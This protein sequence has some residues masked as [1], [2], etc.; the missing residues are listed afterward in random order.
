MR[1]TELLIESIQRQCESQINSSGNGISVEE[2]LDHL[3]AA[4]FGLYSEIV[5]SVPDILLAD[6]YVDL[7]AGQ[8][9]YDLPS[10]LHLGSSIKSIW[11]K[12]GSG[13]ADYVKIPS[14]IEFHR[15][16]GSSSDYPAYYI[17][18]GN[19]ILINPIP[20][21]ASTNGLRISYQQKIRRLDVRRGV[22]ESIT[23]TGSSLD[24]I[25]LDLTPTLGKDGNTLVAAREMLNKADKICVVNRA[26]RSILNNIPIDSYDSA[27]GTLTIGD[28][29]G[30]ID[31]TTTK[32]GAD[33]EGNYVVMGDY[34]T[35]HGDFPD[36][37]VERY[38]LAYTTMCLLRRQGNPD[39][40]QFQIQNM[41]SIKG[42]ILA[43]YESPDQDLKLL[44]PDVTWTGRSD[45][46]GQAPIIS[47]SGS[48]GIEEVD[49][50]NVNLAGY[51]LYKEKVSNT[52]KFLGIDV[53]TGLDIAQDLS[54]DTIDISL[55]IN[56]LTTDASPTT[57]DY[58]L[59]YDVSASNHKKVA[60]SAILALGS[61]VYQPLD[62]TLTSLSSLGTAAD[63]ILYTTAIDTWAE[64]SIS[65]LGRTII[66]QTTLTTHGLLLGQGT[67]A[68]TALGASTNGQ[69]PIG[70]TGADP[71]L[72]SLTAPA[73]GFTITGGA[74]SI[75]FA[76]ADDLAALEGLGS[77]GLAARTASN[78]WAQR[79]IT[80]PAA[81][82]TVTDG[83]GVSGNPTLV[84]AN[85][86]AG[87]EGLTS[88]GLA[89]RS[90]SDTWVQRSVAAGTAI[91]VTNGDGVSGNPTVNVTG[92]PAVTTLTNHGLLIGQSTSAITAMSAGTAG[93]VPVSGGASADPGY[94]TP[95]AAVGL[96]GTFNA[97]THEYALAI[98][99]LTEDTNP[100]L[101]ADFVATYDASASG[102]KKVLLKNCTKWYMGSFTR[103]LTT[104]SGNQ[105]I[106]GVG[107]MPRFII[108]MSTGIQST[109]AAFYSF[110]GHSNASSHAC[111]SVQAGGNSFGQGTFA[112]VVGTSGS[113]YQTF[114][115]ASMDS[116]GFT[117]AW[118]KT[119]TP[120]GTGVIGYVAV[121]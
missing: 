82:I 101:A 4:Q 23:K 72:A 115:I 9:G 99:A 85:D 74:G 98:S 52:F 95:T 102:H 40:V 25:V 1:R 51:G 57:S 105:A 61:S 15:A 31:F 5:Q 35:S 22:I 71:V 46:F 104:A 17:R 84:L 114:T 58:L 6:A 70:S 68:I 13:T 18:K 55:D 21:S 3:N 48:G 87:L 63:K 7:V 86:L 94:V 78:T 77:T 26:G 56:E 49:A 97:S 67:G 89:V 96:T 88:T 66:N 91:S 120:T 79:T 59:E 10:D 111:S 30:D 103:D 107:F 62:A 92:P 29:D 41:Q 100:D 24:T 117:V 83:N 69:L 93:Q 43:A 110:D 76:L 42:D 80:A 75:T 11:H 108:D 112:G 14:N 27:T 20:A 36:E 113:A 50:E 37:T 65:A 64:S 73:A 47:G 8:E 32:T 54:N 109:G 39:E 12:C 106:T 28:T 45:F 121:G 2:I 118:V 60:L 33:F 19:Q 119:S 16:T 116:D 34:S 81:G 90:A 44:L 53:D 38:L